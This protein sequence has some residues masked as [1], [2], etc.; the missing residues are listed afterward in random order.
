MRRMH[1]DHDATWYHMPLPQV[2]G[3]GTGPEPS[4]SAI[5]LFRK[6]EDRLRSAV[7]MIESCPHPCTC[8]AA[9]AGINAQDYEANGWYIGDDW[10]WTKRM[11]RETWMTARGLKEVGTHE[12]PYVFK[13]PDMTDDWEVVG[14][15]SSYALAPGLN[16]T[17][18]RQNATLNTLGGVHG[19]HGCQTK[20]VLGLGC[21]ESHELTA[22]EVE[23]AVH[24]VSEDAA[25][26]G[27]MERY[28]ESV[29]LFHSMHG[30]PLYDF[31]LKGL[32][33]ERLAEPTEDPWAARFDGDDQLATLATDAADDAVYEAA[34][35]RFESLLATHKAD[36][37]ECTKQ[38]ALAKERL[39]PEKGKSLMLLVD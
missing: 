32:D 36:V 33:L 10:G 25:F 20:F 3:P 9:N 4:V 31:E 5:M 23:L 16:S 21:H 30:G 27:I 15:A 1:P 18:A 29:C 14:E 17:F 22:E 26:V 12:T 28:A 13:P 38:V 11:K 19:L 35:T 24:Y 7:N 6:P 2:G 37:D 39:K 8:C 34:L